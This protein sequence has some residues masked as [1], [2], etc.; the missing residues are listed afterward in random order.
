MFRTTE[1]LQYKSPL[2]PLI[3]RLYKTTIFAKILRTNHKIALHRPLIPCPPLPPPSFQSCLNR[4]PF[5]RA[6][7]V[8]NVC[9]S[10]DILGNIITLKF[11]YFPAFWPGLYIVNRDHSFY[12][13]LSKEI[14]T[15]IVSVR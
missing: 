4:M 11:P 3:N 5:R 8:P 14:D 9:F 7:K 2:L 10:L 1:F 6:Q 15:L 13:F 12:P